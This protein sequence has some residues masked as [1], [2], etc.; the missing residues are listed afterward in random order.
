M[1][2]SSTE[3]R[4]DKSDGEKNQNPVKICQSTETV[5]LNIDFTR[6]FRAFRS[7]NAL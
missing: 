7:T 6:T 3:G 5:P 1:R 4:K 2:R